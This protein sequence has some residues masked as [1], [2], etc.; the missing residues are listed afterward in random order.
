MRRILKLT[1]PI[2]K[3]PSVNHIKNFIFRMKNRN[4]RKKL[5]KRPPHNKLPSYIAHFI[6]RSSIE[7]EGLEKT[8]TISKKIR[9]FSGRYVSERTIRR[10]RNI[11]GFRLMKKNYKKY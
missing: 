10:Y 3:V 1:N 9:T 2:Y 5:V 6:L 8:K 11:F 7:S 4:R